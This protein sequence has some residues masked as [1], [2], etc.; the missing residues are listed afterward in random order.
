MSDRVFLA[1]LRDQAEFVAGDG[2]HLRE[3]LHPTQQPIRIGYSLAHAYVDVG[4]RT[5][6]HWLEQSEVYYIIAG[7][8]TMVLDGQAHA[9]EAG[10]YYYIPP[11][12]SQWLRND[13]EQRLEFLCI[14]EPP[15]T[16]AGETITE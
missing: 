2:C 14:V 16:A 7:H 3:L 6:D 13:G 9:I 1:H 5:A 8:G 4:C 12:C 11:R 15:W 10:S